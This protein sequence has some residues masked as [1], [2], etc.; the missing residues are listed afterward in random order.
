MVYTKIRALTH[1]SEIKCASVVEGNPIILFTIVELL[2]Y[3]H[4]QLQLYVMVSDVLETS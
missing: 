2:M 3:I 4:T 1:S